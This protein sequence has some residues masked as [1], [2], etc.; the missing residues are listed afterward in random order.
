MKTLAADFS[1][2]MVEFNGQRSELR[3]LP[4]PLLRYEPQHQPILDGALFAFSLGT[5][6]EVL[7]LLEARGERDRA[8]WQFA[9]ARF[10]FMDLKGFH[11]QREVW[12][13]DGDRGMPG[14][15]IG[16]PKYQDSIYATY[17]VSTSPVEK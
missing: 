7:L 10:H 5:D 12:R 15:N 4:Q 17:Q 6:P 13:V 1:A 2:S 3:L 14:L 11:K 16:S 9:F 8:E